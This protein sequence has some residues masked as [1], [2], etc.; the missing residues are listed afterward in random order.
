MDIGNGA[1]EI[2]TGVCVCD[3]GVTS[4]AGL[5]S[6]V[7]CHVMSCSW[8]L[9]LSFNAKD[10]LI[11]EIVV[12]CSPHSYSCSQFYLG[13]RD[14]CVRLWDPRVNEPVLALEPGEGQPARDCWTVA[15][16]A[17]RGYCSI[18]S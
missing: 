2:V 7:S 3:R 1:P 8:N 13:G 11:A 18:F 15:F 17:C 14:G 9:Y 16:G 6:C 10:W 4:C 5:V 12:L